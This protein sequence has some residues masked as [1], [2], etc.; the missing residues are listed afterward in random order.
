[1]RVSEIG[2]GTGDNAGLLVK[3]TPQQQLAVVERALEL[4]INYFDTSPDYGKGLA[5]T[6]IGKAMRQIGFRPIIA[7]KV[8]VMPD[9]L[10]HVADAVVESV[11][12]SLKRLQVDWVDIVQIHNPPSIVT[13]TT[14]PGWLHLGVNQYLGPDGALE[15]LERLRRDGLVRYFGF[16][17]EDADA[18]AVSILLE[19]G[20][21]HHINVWYD[22]LNPTGGLPK[23]DGLDI[24][25]DYGEFMNRALELGVGISVIRPLAGGVLTD[26]AVAGGARHPLAGGGL[27]RNADMYQAMVARA[28]PFAFLS[29]PGQ[30]LSDAAYRFI[31]QHPA[32][33]CVLGG[34][35]E[36]SHLEEAAACSGAEP[37]SEEDMAR[38]DMV[39]RSNV[40]KWSSSEQ[41]ISGL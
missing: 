3:G 7:T 29:K 5:E 19:S 16:A 10:D 8:E 26:H 34:F 6:N 23:P 12:D 18:Q 33:T 22:L 1:M 20:E 30:R 40:G 21:F 35:S 24:Q 11:H 27:T 15:G 25:H 17:N 13:D 38:L 2:F 32:V 14:V 4:G 31:L 9:E 39:W 28:K 36:M 41:F 37:L